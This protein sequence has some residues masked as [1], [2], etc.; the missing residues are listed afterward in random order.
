MYATFYF[1]LGYNLSKQ[2]FKCFIQEKFIVTIIV[3]KRL[4]DTYL[5]PH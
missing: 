2:N 3:Q 1:F 5:E 4:V